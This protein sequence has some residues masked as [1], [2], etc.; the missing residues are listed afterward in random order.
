MFS[1]I[2]VQFRWE[3]D[4]FSMRGYYKM[5]IFDTFSMRSRIFFI[6][7]WSFR[8]DTFWLLQRQIII[9]NHFGRVGRGRRFGYRWRI[10]QSCHNQDLDQKYDFIKISMSQSNRTNP[11]LI[12]FNLIFLDQFKPPFRIINIFLT[13]ILNWSKLV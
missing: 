2:L 8:W 3:I 12:F 7:N 4:M 5:M 11:A 1:V 13:N 10:L 6:R 9:L